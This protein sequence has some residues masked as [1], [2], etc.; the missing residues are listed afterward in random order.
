MFAVDEPKSEPPAWPGVD[1]AGAP[2]RV[3][4]EEVVVAAAGAP[5]FPK[6]PPPVDPGLF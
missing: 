1:V 4:V 3:G 2:N 5:T 6:I